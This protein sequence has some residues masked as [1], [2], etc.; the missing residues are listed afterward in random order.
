MSDAKRPRSKSARDEIARQV[1]EPLALASLTRAHGD[2][3]KRSSHPLTLPLYRPV[4]WW[5][6]VRGHGGQ[7]VIDR[8]AGK[9][10]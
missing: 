2:R 3:E 5:T 4:T 7:V 6:G 9:Y 1:G 8:R 10:A